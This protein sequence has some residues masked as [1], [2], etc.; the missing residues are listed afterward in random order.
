MARGTEAG[1][2]AA[3]R[4]WQWGAHSYNCICSS[5]CHIELMMKSNSSH[6]PDHRSTQHLFLYFDPHKDY[7]VWESLGVIPPL[8][9]HHMFH[10]APGP[11]IPLTAILSSPLQITSAYAR[12]PAPEQQRLPQCATVSDAHHLS[13][14][15]PPPQFT[16]YRSPLS[17]MHHGC[18][19]MPQKLGIQSWSSWRINNSF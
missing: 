10:T 2:A 1:P 11:I 9:L 16:R 12:I 7:D 15:V 19:K 3:P 8:F 4:H 17:M 6:A 13:D 14:G 18:C 5:L